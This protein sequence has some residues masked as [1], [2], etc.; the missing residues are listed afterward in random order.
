M[1]FANGPGSPGS[2]RGACR[3]P[4]YAVD[5]CLAKAVGAVG[6]VRRSSVPYPWKRHEE[7]DR[8]LSRSGVTQDE[9]GGDECFCPVADQAW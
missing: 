1:G 7:V 2:I 9:L 8:L 6:P 5:R 4:H 3:F